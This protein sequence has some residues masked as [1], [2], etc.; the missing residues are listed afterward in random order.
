MDGLT[1]DERNRLCLSKQTLKGLRKT[2][3]IKIL[4]MIELYGNYSVGIFQLYG[5]IKKLSLN[6]NK[7]QTNL[8]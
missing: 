3:I 4:Q 1:A 6:S 2:A 8:Q 7:I 5:Q